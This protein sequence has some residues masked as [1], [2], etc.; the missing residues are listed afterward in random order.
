M[1]FSVD[2]V[3]SLICKK[4]IVLFDRVLIGNTLDREKVAK[5]CYSHKKLCFFWS[6]YT[7]KMGKD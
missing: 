2:Y 5:C 7:I 3:F 1:G 4:K 6:R